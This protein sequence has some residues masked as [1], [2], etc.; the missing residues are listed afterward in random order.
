MT[1][2]AIVIGTRGS[3]LALA[4]AELVVG[5][6]EWAGVATRILI[7]ETAGDRRAPDT[8]WGEGAFVA[9]IERALLAGSVD[10]AV[11]SAKDVPTEE[12]P[13]LCI[14]AY[15]PRADPRD[16]LVVRADAPWR[17]LDDLPPGTRVGTDSPRRTGFVLA[18]RPDLVV[19]PL[20]GNVDTRL[21]RL[22]AGETDALV[23]A[24]A[25]LD[26]LGLDGRIA[27][28]IE[29][30]VVPPAPGQGAIA[31]QVRR[32]DLRVI[33]AVARIDDPDTRL[34][35]EAERAFLDACGGGCR[36]PIGALGIVAGDELALLGGMART[37]GS[38]TRFERR[39]GPSATGATLARSLAETFERA[40]GPRLAPGI[41]APRHAGPTSPR[42]LVTRTA[43]QAPD[44]MAAL[45]ANGL[46]P[47]SVPA[48][49]VDLVDRDAGLAAALRR[50]DGYA[51]VVVTSANGARAIVQ[52]A[53]GT[54]SALDRVGWAAIG[55]ATSQVLDA[56]GLEVSFQPTRSD[57]AALAAELPIDPGQRVLVVCGDLADGELA[58]VLRRRGATVDDVIGYR[59]HE[60]PDTS[61]ALLRRAMAAG[62]FDGVVLTSGSTARGLVALAR[63]EGLD[64]TSIPAVCIGPETT[65]A[66]RLAG[67]TVVA[68]SAEPGAAALASATAQAVLAHPVE[69]R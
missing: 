50:L 1:E 23:L 7:I 17:Q 58:G 60:A 30:E 61:R 21:R 52:A 57:G 69:V 19:H 46:A 54:G 11:H 47:V 14:G 22:D 29:P 12:D 66:A 42:I 5:A 37:D 41:D 27:E 31:V 8:A 10:V 24:C 49:E 40:D 59:T 55:R 33:D 13:R 62:P 9:A 38:A 35:V 43:D 6:L 2:R 16:A 34:A 53:K 4:Q 65:A 68:V 67:F 36:A 18:R 45:R 56:N 28:R 64:V 48:I 63:A 20:H 25:G 51:W 44:L 32:D 26:R 3:R 39:H 15:L